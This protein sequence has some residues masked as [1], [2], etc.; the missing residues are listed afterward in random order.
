MSTL[1]VG[2]RRRCFP[3]SCDTTGTL[4]RESRSSMIQAPTGRATS[5]RLARRSCASR[6]A[7][8]LPTP[9]AS[10]RT[11]SFFAR[12]MR[13]T[14]NP[15]ESRT[16]SSWWTSMN[17]SITHDYPRSSKHTRTP[18]SR[19]PP[20][21]VSTWSPIIRPRRTS[22]SGRKSA[23]GS[24]T[25]GSLSPPSST[26]KSESTTFPVATPASPREALPARTSPN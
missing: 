20:C 10:S 17:S 5:W 4:P 7:A 22:R 26:L 18:P 21:K 15:A 1:S 9:M 2:T 12:K 8:S 13:L 24:I 11:L 23:R 19:S 14:R 3:I 6:H 16:G 25:H